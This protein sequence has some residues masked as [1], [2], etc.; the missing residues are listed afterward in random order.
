MINSGI[1]LI[2]AL[3]S[4]VAQLEK[5]P[6]MQLI[7][8]GISQD[9]SS[10]ASLSES[11]LMNPDVFSEAEV[12][13]V[14]SGEASGRLNSV[15]ENLANDLEKAH[16][17]KAKVKSAMIYPVVVF[18]LLIAVVAAMMIFV[19][20]KLKSLFESNNA[21]LPLI[22]RIVVGLS[23]FMVEQKFT[24]AVSVLGL[25][26]FLMILKKTDVGKYMI[27]KFKIT[28]PLFG[29]LFK[30]AYLSHFAR[31]L[32][33]LLDSNISIVKTVEITANS[34]GN[35]VYRKS[36]LLSAEDIKQGI[37]LAESLSEN[38]LF[39][40]MLINMIEV[41]EETAQLDEISAKV[42]KFYEDEV[43]TAVAGISKIIEP[44]ILIV[45]GLT[46]GAVVAAIM[47][48]IMQ[49]SNVAGVL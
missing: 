34:V 43:D 32:S 4:L 38:P 14:Q 49:L 21:E 18:V 3:N 11:L 36:L 47:L 26:L 30:K 33:N 20:P 45:I 44:V 2:K 1:P 28:V 41:G 39:P 31:S 8:E 7:V 27:D 37:P 23:D 19:I 9:V 48:P 17:I 15:M 40:P 10:G 46:V 42:A 6:R 16:M 5:N 25:V 35:E 12:G 29:S 22:T 13:M 24:F